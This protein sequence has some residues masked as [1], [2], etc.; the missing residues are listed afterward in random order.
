MAKKK[1]LPKLNPLNNIREE[2]FIGY[3]PEEDD[4]SALK[5]QKVAI[6][7]ILDSP[8]QTRDQMSPAKFAQLVHSIKTIG[9]QGF[10]PVRLHPEQEGYY[11]IVAGGHSRRNAARAAGE[12]EIP[13]VIVDFDERQTGL[14]TA[15]E[16][17]GREDLNIIEKGK[18]F[19]KLR[20]DFDLSQEALASE[21][22][23]DLSRN[24][25][26][27]CEA[28]ALS[29]LDIQAMLITK[30]GGI[31]AAKYLRQLDKLDEQEPGRAVRERAPIIAAFLVEE[32]TTD[33][34]HGA[35]QE[36]I[37]RADR[38]KQKK[39]TLILDTTK[40]SQDPLASVTPIISSSVSDQQPTPQVNGMM[41]HKTPIP[42]TPITSTIPQYSQ[43]EQGPSHQDIDRSEKIEIALKRFQQFKR[44]L[45]ETSPS[46]KERRILS[47]LLNDI[48]TLLQRT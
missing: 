48:Q 3:V 44:L 32:L 30:E 17:L 18:L 37:E 5:V 1:D 40:F 41:T 43:G 8:Y 34:V 23:E 20:H 38:E 6:D 13:I 19:L 28:A 10:I 22:G 12:T 39:T 27:E 9:F 25:I 14:G 4:S 2:G 45:G 46:E 15:L 35:V 24:Q 47:T 36:V 11:Q 33:G 21:L 26:K 29:A 16:N 42:T 7:K 31:R